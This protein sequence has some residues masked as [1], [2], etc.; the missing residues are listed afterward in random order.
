VHIAVGPCAKGHF[1]HAGPTLDPEFFFVALI[2]AY[3]EETLHSL[4][5]PAEVE[6]FF[7]V[8]EKNLCEFFRYKF[9]MYQKRNPIPAGDV[10]NSQYGRDCIKLHGSCFMMLWIRKSTVL[11]S[12]FSKN[13]F[14]SLEIREDSRISLHTQ[15]TSPVISSYFTLLAL[16]PRSQQLST[17]SLL[18]LMIT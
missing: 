8:T 9:S 5:S 6:F 12:S 11:V 3:K 7:L 10:V 1:I 18:H 13:L 4:W 14:C 2:Q 17:P 15:P 16:S